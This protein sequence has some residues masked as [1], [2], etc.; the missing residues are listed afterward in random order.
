MTALDRSREPGVR[1][2]GVVVDKVEFRDIKPGTSRHDPLQFEF[3]LQ[4]TH[5]ADPESVDITV[6]VRVTPK[7]VEGARFILE[8][9][10]TGTFQHAEESP[11]MSLA[12]FAEVNGPAIVFP[13][14]R[15][16]VTNITA[17]S[18]QGLIL[19]PPINIAALAAKQR[20]STSTNVATPE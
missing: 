9:S 5:Y 13:F 1:F 18:R 16:F 4:R 3:A 12:D 2:T 14:V 7:G 8:A 10:V 17:R 20:E 19:M 6:L 11:N 15:E